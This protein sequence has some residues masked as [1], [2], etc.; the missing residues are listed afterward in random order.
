VPI[1]GW[2]AVGYLGAFVSLGA[3][4]LYA[5]ALFRLPASRAAIAINAVPLVALVTGW[6]VLGE[7]LG[8]LQVVGCVAI[9]AGV[10][11]G[12]SGGGQLPEVD[13]GVAEA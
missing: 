6:A 13:T 1:R 4:G 12:Q 8:M 2:L 5:M 7:S 11:L 9:A 3:F 10:A